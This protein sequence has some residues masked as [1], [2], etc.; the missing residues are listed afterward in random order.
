MHKKFKTWDETAEFF[1]WAFG[2]LMPKLSDLGKWHE[3]I[4]RKERND[5]FW[6]KNGIYEI[7]QDEYIGRIVEEYKKEMKDGL[8]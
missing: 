6:R 4:E 8:R 3:R 7:S 5:K 2:T 1:E